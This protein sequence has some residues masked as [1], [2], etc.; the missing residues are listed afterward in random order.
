MRK[1]PLIAAQFLIAVLAAVTLVFG[2]SI[3][4]GIGLAAG[5]KDSGPTSMKFDAKGAYTAQGQQY[6]KGAA[7][8]NTA[9]TTTTE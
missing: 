4:A 1:T 9:T 3:V 7:T 5:C 6:T 2:L 8:G